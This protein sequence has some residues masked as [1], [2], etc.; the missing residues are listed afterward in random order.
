MT[1]PEGVS[2]QDESGRLWDIVW[3]LRFAIKKSCSGSDRIPVAL[4]V[5]N[6]NRAAK[7]VRLVATCGALDMDDPRPA[8][9]VMMPDED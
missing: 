3:M 8:I 6:N 2:G 5:R 4:H 7:L 9:T 1:V